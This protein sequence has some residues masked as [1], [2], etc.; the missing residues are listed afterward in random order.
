MLKKFRSRHRAKERSS[1]PPPI[2]PITLCAPSVDGK[3]PRLQIEKLSLVVLGDNGTG[4]TCLC[5][6]ISQ[7]VWAEVAL[8]PTKSFN[9]YDCWSR[10]V[11]T[12]TGDDVV[13]LL[14]DTSQGI[15]EGMSITSFY[16]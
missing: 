11:Q 10:L 6:R 3:D 2:L 15:I 4:K 16:R 8:P 13:A 5:T 1:I 9:D 14:L 7:D 12:N